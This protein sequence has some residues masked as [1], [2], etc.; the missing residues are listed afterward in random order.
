MPDVRVQREA[1]D[2]GAELGGF[3]AR[4]PHAGGVATFIGRMRDFRGPDRATGEAVSAMTL[5]HYPGMAERELAGLA[6]QAARRWKLDGALIVHRVGDLAPG[7]AIVFV[8]TAAAHRADA[9]DACA[10]LIDWLKTR[11]PFWKKETVAEGASWVD[12]AASDEARAA[13]WSPGAD[14]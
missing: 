9:L 5:E 11:A 12:A 2:P 8:A 1:F 7:D 6:A 10:F 3:L 4:V 14:A 13:R